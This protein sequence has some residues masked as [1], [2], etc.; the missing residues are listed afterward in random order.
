M[1]GLFGLLLFLRI[2]YP[3]LSKR[4]EMTALAASGVLFFLT[5]HTFVSSRQT[6]PRTS[7]QVI[8][9]RAGR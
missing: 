4:K 8:P 2:R 6:A 9:V 1:V 3:N 7:G 5:C